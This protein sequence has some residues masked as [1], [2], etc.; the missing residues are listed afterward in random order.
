MV[1]RKWVYRILRITALAVLA[2]VLLRFA[3]GQFQQH[4]LGWRAERPMADMHR[5]RLYQNA[6]LFALVAGSD[7][8]LQCDGPGLADA[9]CQH[10]AGVDQ[11]KSPSGI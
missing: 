9:H 7:R 10:F 6:G 8:P 4:L 3:V 2:V 5:I 1:Y 11:E